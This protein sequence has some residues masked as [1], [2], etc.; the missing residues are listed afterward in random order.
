MFK[1]SCL[2]LSLFTLLNSSACNPQR[3][4]E[5][6]RTLEADVKQLKTEVA[7]LKQ[8]QKAAPE[9]HYELRKDDFRTWRFDPSTGETCIQLTSTA[10]WK[11]KETMYQSCDCSEATQHWTEMPFD[12]D[13]QQKRADSYFQHVQRV[14][15]E[16]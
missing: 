11:R 15:G 5:K 10:D 1:V 12:T 9:H 4:D 13:Q 7:E 8:K 16:T 2:L 14:C 3:Q 6:V